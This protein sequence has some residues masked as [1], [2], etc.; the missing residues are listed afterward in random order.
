VE[1]RAETPDEPRLRN[2]LNSSGVVDWWQPGEIQ[3]AE[4]FWPKGV[5]GGSGR[6]LGYVSKDCTCGIR[7]MATLRDLAAFLAH[8]RQIHRYPLKAAVVGRVRIGGRVEHR[9]PGLPRR[10]G[11][12]RSEFAV[13]AGPLYVSPFGGAKHLDALARDYRGVEVVAPDLPHTNAQEWLE[14]LAAHV[15]RRTA[16]T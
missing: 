12:A 10:E 7:S 11:Y 16:P 15:E 2:P 5:P 1:T 9:I 13:L 6:C 8:D 3:R 14:E 4:C